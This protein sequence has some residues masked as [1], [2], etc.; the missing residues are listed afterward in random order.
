M[1]FLCVACGIKRLIDYLGYG[2]AH[3]IFLN[4]GV[5]SGFAGLQNELRFVVKSFKYQKMNNQRI[6][7]SA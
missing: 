4:N 1:G 3:R 5:I 2:K 6:L 7:T